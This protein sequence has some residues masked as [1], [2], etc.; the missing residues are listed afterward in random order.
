MCSKRTHL[1][2]VSTN[3]QVAMSSFGWTDSFIKNTPSLLT[4]SLSHLHPINVNN[5]YHEIRSQNSFLEDPWFCSGP[6]GTSGSGALRHPCP[7]TPS[8][9]GGPPGWQQRVSPGDPPPPSC[10]LLGLLLLVQ[11]ADYLL[12]C[13]LAGR[14]LTKRF[15]VWLAASH[16]CFRKSDFPRFFR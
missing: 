15:S 10:G 6:G 8:P 4:P 2:G 9:G 5:H 14:P 1:Y 16:V 11:A 7:G 13:L 12:S 3:S